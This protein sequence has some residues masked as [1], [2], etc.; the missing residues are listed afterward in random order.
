MFVLEKAMAERCR[1]IADVDRLCEDLLRHGKKS[2]NSF[3]LFSSI[4]DAI[5]EQ[6]DHAIKAL[7]CYSGLLQDQPV[8]QSQ[9]NPG[10]KLLEMVGLVRRRWARIEI[11]SPMFRDHFDTAEI[12]EMLNEVSAG[13]VQYRG[14]IVPRKGRVCII[15]TGGTIGMVPRGDKIE[16]AE[17]DAE[18]R[19]Y[20]PELSGIA[21]VDFVP[22]YA[23]D[24]INVYPPVWKALA[25]Y[26]YQ[27][28]HDYS[29][30]VVAHGTDTMPFTASALAFALGEHLRFPVVFTGAQT[31]PDVLH[32]DARTN[33]YRACLVAQTRIHEVVICFGEY[34]FRACRAQKKD[35]RRF[36]GFESPTYPPLAVITGEVNVQSKLLRKLPRPRQEINLRTEFEQGLLPVVQ[37]PGLEPEFF[38]QNLTK[39]AGK[40]NAVKGI[41]VQ[42][43]G[44]GNVA[45]IPPFSF[46]E[47][48]NKA[49]LDG[50][51]VIITSQY[52]PDPG[53]HT[54]YAPAI[55]PIEAGAIHAGNM[56]VAAAV[57]KFRWV[58][59]QVYA[60]PEWPSLSPAEKRSRVEQLMVKTDFVG[61][62]ADH[63]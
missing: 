18:L 23:L 52:P 44:A 47:F 39:R 25:D 29:G 59:A 35:D 36:D 6:K 10:A 11:K 22:M 8:A 56:T 20:F 32:G 21:K 16:P 9:Y 13:R 15:N 27:R 60:R 37:Y 14:A 61:E 33:L 28:Q 4:R 51:P 26:I 50:I 54:K 40:N 38:S 63:K 3:G 31:T 46:M 42:T 34:V 30:F 2:G 55:A 24:S 41:I 5:L 53:S 7:H 62:L 17:S 12:D 43:L 57:T 1:S 58:L 48:I 19:A 49:Y 45:N